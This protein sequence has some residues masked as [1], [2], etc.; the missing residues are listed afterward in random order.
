LETLLGL[1]GPLPHESTAE[2]QTVGGFVV[3]QLGRIPQAGDQFDWA[4]W[5]FQVAG[6]DRQRVDQMR[7]A[8]I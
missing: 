3:T 7:I 2:F 1:S 4:G 6:M 8:R 5:R